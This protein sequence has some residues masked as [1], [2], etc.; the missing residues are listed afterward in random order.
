MQQPGEVETQWVK[1]DG[2][3]IDVW[4]ETSTIQGAATG[5]FVRSRSVARPYSGARSS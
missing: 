4:I 2:T 3:V 5:S 1:Q